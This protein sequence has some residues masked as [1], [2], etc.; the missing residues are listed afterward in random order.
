MHQQI[1]VAL[2]SAPSSDTP[3]AMPA[4]EVEG[5]PFEVQNGALLKL[6]KLVASKGYDLKAA[7]G[8]FIESGGV[9]VF[10]VE[11]DDDPGRPRA[12]ADLLKDEGY[13]HVD[14]VAPFH[15]D[16][17]DVIGALARVVEE[18]TRDGSLVQ[19]ILVGLPGDEG[20]PIQV[21]TLR[22]TRSSGA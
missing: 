16:V 19:E 18:A 2:H 8:H 5:T 10:A 12:I 20:V 7:S 22:H 6:L 9:F 14:V 13:K 21:T 15:R 4:T 11:D 1:R 17:K 3:G